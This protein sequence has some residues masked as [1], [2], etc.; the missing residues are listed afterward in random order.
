MVR[1]I[2]HTLRHG[3]VTACERKSY[4]LVDGTFTEF[5]PP[6]GIE[7]AALKQSD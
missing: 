2:I 3:T 7:T 6:I 1:R 5:G 4:V